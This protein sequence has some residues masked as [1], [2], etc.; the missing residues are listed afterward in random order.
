MRKCYD[1]RFISSHSP[2]HRL[3]TS[4]IRPIWN[5]NLARSPTHTHATNPGLL[6]ESLWKYAKHDTNTIHVNAALSL[7]LSIAAIDGRKRCSSYLHW[8][9]N[10]VRQGHMC[11][12]RQ[13]TPLK[14]NADEM[15]DIC[16]CEC[17][18][19]YARHWQRIIAVLLARHFHSARHVSCALFA[20]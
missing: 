19:A 8:H 1:F 12:I 20:V 7:A 18:C 10:V 16:K 5:S 6:L 11:N 13:K 17:A 3:N 15:S 14:R 4:L 9:W 2:S